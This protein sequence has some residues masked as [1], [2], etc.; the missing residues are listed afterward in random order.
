MVDSTALRE[1]R[2]R[3]VYVRDGEMD[4]WRIMRGDGKL[5]GDCEDFS[6]TLVWMMCDKSMIKFWLAIIF[7]RYRIWYCKSPSGVGHAI[8]CHRGH[9]TDNIQRVWVA[10]KPEARGYKLVMPFLA[11]MLVL[12]MLMGKFK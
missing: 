1:L 3:H 10:D 6:L 8:V 7:M 4:S 9:W 2:N 12:K 11:P 5:R